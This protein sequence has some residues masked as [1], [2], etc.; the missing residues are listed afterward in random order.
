MSFR[1][2]TIALA[3]AAVAV[4]M[5]TV[6]AYAAMDATLSSDHARPGDWVLLLTDDN[7]G[8]AIY[9]DLSAEGNQLIYLAPTAGEFTAGCGGSGAKMVG[10]LAWRGNRGGVAFRVPTLP[11]G[12]YYLFMET[13]AQCWRIAGTVSGTHGPLVLAI[14]NVVADNQNGAATWSV[15]SL[16]PPQQQG[17]S[18]QPAHQPVTS[19]PIGQ[20]LLVVAI[21]IVAL[22]VAA[23]TWWRWL[24]RRSSLS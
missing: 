8:K 22:L 10:R 19:A 5:G 1:R 23:A 20:Q 11:L 2:S 9:D 14:G 4:L 3:I 12:T 16:G 21:V 18:Q 17:P 6:T 13:H 7:N 15:D 24:R